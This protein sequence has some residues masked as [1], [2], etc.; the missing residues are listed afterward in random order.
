M[1][2]EESKEFKSLARD[3]CVPS[4][5]IDKIMATCHTYELARI[6]MLDLVFNGSDDRHDNRKSIS[7]V[8][9]SSL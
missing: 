8:R 9:F 7:G 2:R 3:F 6:K 4:P 5:I 1:S